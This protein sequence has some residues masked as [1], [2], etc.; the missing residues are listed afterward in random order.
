M[1]FFETS[2]IKRLRSAEGEGEARREGWL[3]IIDAGGAS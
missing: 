3:D 2:P 1:S